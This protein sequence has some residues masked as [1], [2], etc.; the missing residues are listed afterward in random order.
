MS[1]PRITGSFSMPEAVFTVTG[2]DISAAGLQ[3][4]TLQAAGRVGGDT[5]SCRRSARGAAGGTITA[6]GQAS[7]AA[8][9][10]AIRLDW[11]QLD[12]A[13]LMRQ[14]LRRDG[15]CSQPAWTV[16]STRNGRRRGWTRSASAARLD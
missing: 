6:R 16:R 1:T 2:R 9:T 14:I 10:G 7:L 15:S 3:G 8:G 12:L 13:T 11:R 4:M 5:P